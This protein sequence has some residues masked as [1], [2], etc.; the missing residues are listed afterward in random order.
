MKNDHLSSENQMNEIDKDLQA[1]QTL[2]LRYDPFYQMSD[3]YREY[4]RFFQ[5]RRDLTYLKN[6]L[7]LWG[8][9]LTIPV[10]NPEAGVLE[11]V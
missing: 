11:Y 2:R 5:M 3:D 1:F 10:Y 7:G 9:D 8:Q 6:Q 4:M